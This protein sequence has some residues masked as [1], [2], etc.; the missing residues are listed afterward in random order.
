[1]WQGKC[2]RE[3]KLQKPVFNCQIGNTGKFFYIA[4]NESKSQ[5]RC[6]GG[7]EQIVAAD[8]GT[9]AFQRDSQPCIMWLDIWFE[10]KHGYCFK[11]LI[12]L[13]CQ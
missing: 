8:R 11:E 4:G 6:M 1:M 10:R 9:A 3:E 7:D 13:G 12:Y 5:G 2:G